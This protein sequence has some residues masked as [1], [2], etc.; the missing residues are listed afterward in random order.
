MILGF[1][2]KE[3]LLKKYKVPLVK[4][5]IVSSYKGALTSAQKFG[6]PVVLKIS[7]S[8]IL[9]K[10]ET[11]GVIL[12]IQ[13]KKLLLDG[14][15]K[16]S[17]IANKNKASILLQKQEEGTQIIIGAKQDATF[18]PIIMFGLGGIFTE[19]LKDVSFRLA[20]IT[21]KEAR[22]MIE[23]IQG[24]KILKGFRGQGRV[25]LLRLEEILLSSSEM[26]VK[27]KE[28]KEI[29]FNPII[30]NHKKAIVVDA[31]VLI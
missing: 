29:D 14:W 13:N 15:K 10:T 1:E 8:N 31:K 16:I 2:K 9:H 5:E 30:A 6:W 21:R 28:I 24:Y 23:E 20:P 17:K 3:K 11:G 25:N 22:E 18:G 7:S 26:I 19:V 4:G 27:E 12:N